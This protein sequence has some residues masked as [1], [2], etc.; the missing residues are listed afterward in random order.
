MAVAS[1]NPSDSR[2]LIQTVRGVGYRID[3]IDIALAQADR[4]LATLIETPVIRCAP[5]CPTMHIP[6]ATV[7][8]SPSSSPT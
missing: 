8:S 7:N 3:G 4:L 1:G 5:R 2:E 6:K